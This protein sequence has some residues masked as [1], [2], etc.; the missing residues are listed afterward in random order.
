MATPITK[1]PSPACTK[2]IEEITRIYKSLPPRPSILEIEASI[3]VI[4]SVETEEKIEL[5]EISK[6]VVE[7]E[8]N[9]PAELFSVLQQVRKAMV[10]FQS[11]EQRKEAVQLIELDKTYQ[12]FDVLIQEATELISGDTQMGKINSFEDPIGEIGKKDENLMKGLVTSCE[13]ITVSS[14]GL[15]IKHKEKYSLM[16]VAA[17]IENAAKTRARVVDLHNKLMD[18]IEWLPLSLG[19]LVNVTELNVADNQIM[20]LPTTIG[21]LNALT[22]LDLHSNQIINLPDSFGEL[23]NLTDLD[24]HANRLKSL[25]ASFRNLVN[26]IDLDL[27]SNRFAHLPDFVGNLTSLKRL[28]VET[29]QLEELPYTVGFCSSL[30]EL[31]LDFNQLKALPEAMGML[32]H[33]EILT[34]HIN[35]VKGLPT[36]MGNLSHLRELD[37]SFN[38][39]ENIPETFCFAVSLEKLN[40][41]NNFADLKTLPRSIGN[42]ENLE[43]L[44][45]SNSQIR[46]LPD[47]F[48]LLSKLKT[49]RADETPLEVPPRQIIKLGAQVVVEYMAEFVA[50]NELQLQRPKRRRAF[51]SLSCLF[52]NTERKRRI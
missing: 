6:K 1:T 52:P 48:R 50:K 24:L 12:D 3:S 19:K 46:T 45:I 26:L 13:L 14:S 20:A 49:F 41:A 29:N 22:K 36:T 47:S 7:I 18:K 37:V 23:I 4:K 44:D 5:D 42:L 15:G 21:S 2:F 51:F 34:L 9:V 25:P 16:K 28:N 38:E 33:L 32:E 27:G 11:K 39:V 8:E 40:L 43:E 17:L 30:V 10:L 31:R 35:R